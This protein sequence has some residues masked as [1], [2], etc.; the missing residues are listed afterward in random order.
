MSASHRTGASSSLA[1]RR[2]GFWSGLLC[3]RK[4]RWKWLPVSGVFFQG[5]FAAER[6]VQDGDVIPPP[7]HTPVPSPARRPPFDESLLLLVHSRV[8]AEDRRDPNKSATLPPCS[9]LPRNI[10]V[11]LAEQ[12]GTLA[13]G[14]TCSTAKSHHHEEAHNEAAACHHHVVPL[15]CWNLVPPGLG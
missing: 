3:C 9:W 12:R 5:F 1:V 8:R 11:S 6:A 14:T 7:T 2:R 13:I 4:L 10:T 15:P